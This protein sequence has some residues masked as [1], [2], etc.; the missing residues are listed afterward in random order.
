MNEWFRMYLDLFSSPATLVHFLVLGLLTSTALWLRPRRNVRRFLQVALGVGLLAA[1]VPAIGITQVRAAV[2][3]AIWILGVVGVYTAVL[4][5]LVTRAKSRWS[6]LV[7]SA[8]LM[9][10]TP[11]SIMAGLAIVCVVGHN[12]V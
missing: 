5:V 10:L 6:I 2:A 1:L 11:F 4:A 9:M 7:A 3:E 8:L 12:C